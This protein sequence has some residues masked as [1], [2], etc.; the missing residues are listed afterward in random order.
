VIRRLLVGSGVAVWSALG[1]LIAVSARSLVGGL[2]WVALWLLIVGGPL[3]VALL[4][5]RR[6]RPSA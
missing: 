5:Y 3:L 4:L 1:S 6:A 2:L